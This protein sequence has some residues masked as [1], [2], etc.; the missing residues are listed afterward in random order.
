MKREDNKHTTVTI[1]DLCV[2][3]KSSPGNK[4]ASYIY[5]KILSKA[6]YIFFFFC[7]I[8]CVPWGIEPTTFYAANAML[9][10]WATGT[11]KILLKQF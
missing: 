4:K 10:N 5:Q 3:F 6:T 2:F 1:H 11:L 9:Y 8:L 7:I